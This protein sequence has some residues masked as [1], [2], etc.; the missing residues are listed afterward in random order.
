MSIDFDEIDGAE[1]RY[2]VWG[3]DRAQT[4]IWYG[5]EV[6]RAETGRSAYFGMGFLCREIEPDRSNENRHLA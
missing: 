4:T 5:R 3:D 6:S 2:Q 1:M